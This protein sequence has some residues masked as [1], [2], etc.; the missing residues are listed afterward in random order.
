MSAPPPPDGPV[1][2]N[3]PWWRRWWVIA[4]A[5]LVPVL[6]LAAIFSSD[7]DDEGDET[8][9]ADATTSTEPEPEPEAEP[10]PE[11]EPEPEP[12]CISINTGDREQ[13]R[14]WQSALN[15]YL[16]LG[17]SVD[18][19]WGP[20]TEEATEAASQVLGCIEPFRV[21]LADEPAQ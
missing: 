11:R 8:E 6:V 9:S 21:L 15:I 4:L 18:G 19:I 3:K 5:V 1:G 17:V 14:N 10:E 7:S 20:K 13:V 12:E 2:E 16:D